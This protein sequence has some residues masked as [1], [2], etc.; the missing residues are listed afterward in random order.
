MTLRYGVGFVLLGKILSNTVHENW[1]L[2]P[3]VV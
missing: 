2:W 3:F 1:P